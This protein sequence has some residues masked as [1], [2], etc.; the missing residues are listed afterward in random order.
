MIDTAFVLAGGL[1]TRLRSVVSDVPKPMAPVSGRPFLEHLFDY[2]LRQ[3]VE[4]IVLCVGHLGHVIFGHF[5]SSY[6]GIKISYSFEN[7]Q[8]G[9]GGALS[10]ALQEFQPANPFLVCN[11]DTYFPIDTS[12]LVDAVRGQAWAIA[13]FRSSD[14]GR[15]TSLSI[16]S[17][18][19]LRDVRSE[20]GHVTPV[21]PVPFQA[22]S[23]VWIGNPREINLPLLVSETNYSLEDYLSQSLRENGL[24][25]VASE[26]D[27]TFIDIGLPQDFVRAQSMPPFIAS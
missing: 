1:G 15:Y 18:G 23:G 14:S 3:G 7:E 19:A 6:R 2:L 12:V 9:T 25:A 16:G 26:F 22:N 8:S 21:S 27:A 4:H 11:G 5:N 13:T 17:D 20:F 24:S 10:R